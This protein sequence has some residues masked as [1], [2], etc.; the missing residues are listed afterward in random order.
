MSEQA[1]FLTATSSPQK[2]LKL[3]LPEMIDDDDVIQ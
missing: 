2:K 1:V 3:S